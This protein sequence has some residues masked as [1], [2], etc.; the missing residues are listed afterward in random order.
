MGCCKVRYTTRRRNLIYGTDIHRTG[1]IARQYFE[2]S[3]LPTEV[4]VK[5]WNLADTQQQGALGVTGFIIA[6]HLLNSL[7]AGQMRE[8][9]PTIPSPL[10][11]AASQRPPVVSTPPPSS[12]PRQFSG[13]QAQRAGSPLNRPPPTAQPTASAWVIGP[14]EKDGYDKLFSRVDTSGTGYVT[15]DQAVAFFRESGLP[16]QVLADIWDLANIRKMDQL[17][18]DEFAVAMKLINTQRGKQQYDVPTFLPPEMIPPSLRQFSPQATGLAT[19]SPPPQQQPPRPIPQK[20]ATEDLFGLDAITSPPA[21]TLQQQG[22]GGSST[23]S[24]SFDTDPFGSKTTSPTTTTFQPSRGFKPFV[25]TS[26]FGQTLQS[27]GTGGSATSSTPQSSQVLPKVPS[28]LDDLLGDND[29]EVSKKLTTET[30]ELANMSNQ[31]GQ[32]RTQMQEVQNNRSV[33][34]RDLSATTAQKRD[35][36][37]RLTQFRNQY[38]QEVKAVNTL[39]EQLASQRKENQ[40]MQTDVAVL[41]GTLQDLQT[42]HRQVAVELDSERRNNAALKERMRQVNTEV[43]RLRPELDKM[44]NETRHEKGLV[45]INKKQ[46]EKSETERD[47]I[48]TEMDNI[49][50]GRSGSA[51]G[52]A[53]SRDAFS[54]AS[55][56]LSPASQSTNPFFRRSPQ[57]S[58]DN[59][60]SPGGFVR[61]P[62]DTNNK[63]DNIFGTTIPPSQTSAAP[64]TTF[65]FSGQAGQLGQSGPSLT[66][67]SENNAQTPSASPPVSSY[68]PRTLEAPEPPESRQLTS[69][70][71]PLRLGRQPSESTGTSV[72]VETPVSRLEDAGVETPTAGTTSPS[73]DRTETNRTDGTTGAALFE[74]AKSSSPVASVSSAGGR[75]VES[76][77]FAS[78]PGNVPG[79]FPGGDT[80]S[81]KPTATGGS[82]FSA[83][84]RE[85]TFPTFGKEP[86]RSGTTGSSKDFDAAFATLGGQQSSSRPST[87]GLRTNGNL[88]DAAVE[89]IDSEFPP[90][91]SLDESEDSD[92]HGGFDDDFTHPSLDRKK[93][94]VKHVSGL[95]EELSTLNAQKSQP[96]HDQT[97]STGTGS[98][99]RDVNAFPPEF[100]GLTPSREIPTSG[101]QTSQSP[102]QGQALFGGKPITS[103]SP[104]VDT[105]SSSNVPSSDTYHSATSHPSA[106][107]SSSHVRKP[108]DALDDDF[109]AGFEDLEDAKADDE[110]QGMGDDE[111][112]M[113]ASAHENS[114]EEFNPI[115]DSPAASKT[116]TLASER[117]PTNKASTAGYPTGSA[118]DD[119]ADFE[120]A[121]GSGSGTGA[122]G[123]TKSS[124]L[125]GAS[126][127]G[128]LGVPGGAAAAAGGKDDW[129]TMMKSV[130]NTGQADAHKSDVSSNT[131]A[132]KSEQ[133]PELERAT[134]TEHDDPIV[135]ELTGMGFPRDRSVAVLE[136]YDYNDEK[137]GSLSVSIPSPQRAV[138]GVKGVSFFRASSATVGDEVVKD[139]KLFHEGMEEP[140]TPCSAMTMTPGH[141][142]K[143]ELRKLKGL[144]AERD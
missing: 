77:A 6:M 99:T 103:P 73:L 127:L 106:V 102:S 122:G 51:S 70:D 124:I 27:Q 65:G 26:S 8:L 31:I 111:D 71:L 88:G 47:A 130:S 4:L 33:T 108:T 55:P 93:D 87:G 46:L 13:S 37:T 42:T 20:S 76:E 143:R 118:M 94:V 58:F 15:G 38:E 36:E 2:R 128:A 95:R 129:D 137:V 18:R 16:D 25:P 142:L 120:N 59:T 109:E 115:F 80:S 12:I 79:A 83:G 40:R 35:L 131:I 112:F 14:V 114:F 126:G 68:S 34:E 86:L 30:T 97:V 121:F 11:N 135:K 104:A 22:T 113:F 28:A 54:V 85:N 144:F 81:V 117:T 98:N 91:A 133:R 139:K 105:A 57:Q 23:A 84:S 56:A 43:A 67:S 44:R 61:G 21:P 32:L 64:P 9:P 48:K 39:K 119:F 19:V 62:Q 7:K 74:R 24:R 17:N 63:Y 75:P 10:W 69:G 29:P 100:G 5:V 53:T 138:P 45:S 132:G 141:R 110:G 1:D 66:S 107:P 134:T 125:S 123:M 89:R 60:M 116:N 140:A 49:S 82:G 78:F 41:E 136:K 101:P 72:R 90:I 52:S 3:G 96:T 50:K 92:D